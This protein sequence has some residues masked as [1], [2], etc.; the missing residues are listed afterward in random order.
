MNRCV[1]KCWYI[2]III[3]YIVERWNHW[4]VNIQKGDD[5]KS[6]ISLGVDCVCRFSQILF[7]EYKQ[8]YSYVFPYFY[9]F[10]SSKIT[11]EDV[12]SL[13]FC[14]IDLTWKWLHF[15]VLL[16]QRKEHKIA[17]LNPSWPQE[18]SS[19]EWSCYNSM[20]GEAFTFTGEKK[21]TIWEK[22]LKAYFWFFFLHENYLEL[23]IVLKIL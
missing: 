16:L 8:I 20:Q 15:T 17:Q 5:C 21:W 4:I 18:L 6:Y 11:R 3:L 7:L 14:P 12:I 13:C 19:L 2:W 22:V 23:Y 10:M 1:Q 9:H